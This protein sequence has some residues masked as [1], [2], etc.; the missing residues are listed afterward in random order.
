MS[1]IKTKIATNIK[2]WN[3]YLHVVNTIEDW[4]RTV[5]YNYKLFVKTFVEDSRTIV[6]VSWNSAIMKVSYVT[7]MGDVVSIDVDI[8]KWFNFLEGLE[9]VVE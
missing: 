6:D 3:S 8:F 5:E 2:N 4:E 7:N 9:D 1:D